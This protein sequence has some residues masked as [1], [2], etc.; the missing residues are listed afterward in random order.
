MRE[1]TFHEPTLHHPLTRGPLYVVLTE[2]GSGPYGRQIDEEPFWAGEWLHASIPPT[3]MKPT[4]GFR[5][6]TEP[7]DAW[8]FEDMRVYEV[9][10]NG[11]SVW[12]ELDHA[13]YVQAVQLVRPAAN[14][15]WF[16]AVR[17]FVAVDIATIDLLQPDRLGKVR[18]QRFQS[19]E[20]WLDAIIKARITARG[21]DDILS[22]S[23]LSR[24][25][26][27]VRSAFPH[28]VR[29][30]PY[31]LFNYTA[32]RSMKKRLSSSQVLGRATE[33]II[34]NM[35]AAAGAMA[36]MLIYEQIA[37][38]ELHD[39]L[40]TIRACWAT[41]ASGYALVGVTIDGVPLVAAGPRQEAVR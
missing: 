3:R 37:A 30:T 26:Y 33:R 11:K 19:S 18:S 34:L 41:I 15:L 40:D 1:H 38:S 29:Q 36:T 9:A 12:F 24:C 39:D 13:W 23:Y 25:A 16:E 6:S 17:E 7:W 20:S 21:D 10:I 27:N 4:N 31:A 2:D 8:A 32:R 22:C 14:P 35:Q 28:N 5:V